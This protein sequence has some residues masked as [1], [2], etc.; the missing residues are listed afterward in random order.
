MYQRFPVSFKADNETLSG[1]FFQPETIPAPCIIMT[2]GFTALIEHHLAAFAGVFAQAGF[3]VLVYDHRNCG[4]STGEPRYEIDPEIQIKDY[5]HAITYAQSL[6][7]VKSNAIGIWGTSYSGGHV[8]VVAAND[9]RVKSVVTQVPFIKGHH[10]YLKQKYPK[11]WLSILKSYEN[12]QLDRE[13]GKAPQKIPVVSL[14]KN[15][16]AVMTSERAYHF[17]MNVKS[18]PNEVT[19][20]SVAMSGDYHPIN[21]V[22]ET[23]S[24]PILFIVARQDE[25]NPSKFAIEAYEKASD[26]KKLILLNGDHFSAYLEEF[27]LAA[28][29]ACDW[30]RDTLLK[31]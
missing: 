14:D 26:P 23:K 22:E 10:D 15:I 31:N 5:S 30:Y 7:S 29:S 9:K 2:H 17:F 27:S 8:I 6:P 20:Q 3:C 18:W 16:T 19:L 28:Q 13:T 4:V 12:D 25:I 11:K 1:W 21:S 24:I